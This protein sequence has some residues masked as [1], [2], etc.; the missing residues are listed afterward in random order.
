METIR[1]T[2]KELHEIVENQKDAWYVFG[3]GKGYDSWALSIRYGFPDR[4]EAKIFTD[5]RVVN[6]VFQGDFEGFT[7]EIERQLEMS[8]LLEEER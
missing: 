2:R 8:G 1:L 3:N 7:R 6:V 5:S 4:S